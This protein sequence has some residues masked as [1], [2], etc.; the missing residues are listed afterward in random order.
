[1]TYTINEKIIKDI[2]ELFDKNKINDSSFR[3]RI[4][5]IL[6]DDLLK[7][8]ICNSFTIKGCRCKKK[9]KKDELYCGVHLKEKQKL[10]EYLLKKNIEELNSYKI[11]KEEV[12]NTKINKEEVANTKINKEEVA[13]TKI[14]KEEVANTKI[15][16]EEVAN[17]KI[18]KEEVANTNLE[19]LYESE[20]DNLSDSENELLESEENNSDLESDNDYNDHV[21]IKKSPVIVR[22]QILNINYIN[23]IN[24]NPDEL[25]FD[26]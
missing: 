23:N 11:N 25:D 12:A 9:K 22:K 24:M 14:N 3:T 8:S 15:N 21:E 17:T 19:I 18:N 7:D 26:L 1:M 10:K 16:K 2:I 5:Q 4:Q 13:N 6:K 20:D